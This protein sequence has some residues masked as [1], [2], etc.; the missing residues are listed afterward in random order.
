ML[1]LIIE[2][3]RCVVLVVLLEWLTESIPHLVYLRKC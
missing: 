3:G 1:P 2:V